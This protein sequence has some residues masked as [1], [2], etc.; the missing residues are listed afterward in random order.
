MADLSINRTLNDEV[1]A[2]SRRAV[3]DALIR[4]T[5][6]NQEVPVQERLTYTVPEVAGMLGISRSSAYLCVRRGEIPA[7][8]LGRRVVVSRAALDR[9]LA[10]AE[11]AAPS[12]QTSDFQL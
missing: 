12:T 8:T 1:M 4:I 6:P 11:E 10:N 5:D 2:L 3:P 7:L 9:L